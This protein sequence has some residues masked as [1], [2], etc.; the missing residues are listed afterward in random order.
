MSSLND[1]SESDMSDAAEYMVDQL[2]SMTDCDEC[3]VDAQLQ[4]IND[5]ESQSENRKKR[6]TTTDFVLFVLSYVIE[7]SLEGEGRI[8]NIMHVY[9]ITHNY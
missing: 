7:V 4:G 2:N 6:Q 8:M 1:A 9:S 5:F 3:D